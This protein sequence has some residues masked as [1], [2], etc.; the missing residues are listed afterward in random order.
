MSDNDEPRT[1]A[2]DDDTFDNLFP[3]GRGSRAGDAGGPAGPA[4]DGIGQVGSPAPPR[5]AAVML[6]WVIITASVLAIAVVGFM[7]LRGQRSQPTTAVSNPLTTAQTSSGSSSTSSSSS[8]PS[9]STSNS[10][11]SSVS[12]PP[13][14]T[15]APP[16]FEK[17]AGTDTGYRVKGSGTTCPFVADVATRAAGQAASAQDGKFEL[18]VSSAATKKTYEVS[19]TVQAYI[20]CSLPGSQGAP[21]YIYVVRS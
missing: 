15:A 13:A 7:L 16:G 9:S 4:F 5:R 21:T 10:T 2:H 17:C 8:S 3:A 6:P 12:T 14:A 11:S 19:C 20:E 18:T 1:P